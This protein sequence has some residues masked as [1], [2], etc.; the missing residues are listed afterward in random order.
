MKSVRQVSMV[1]RDVALT[2]RVT[3]RPKKLNPLCVRYISLVCAWG[4]EWEDLVQGDSPN[5]D[6]DEEA[7]DGDGPVV[8]N[9]PPA[10][11][12]VEGPVPPGVGAADGEVQDDHA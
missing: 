3:D 9:L 10:L 7:G 2:L 8:G 6:H 5:A 4:K 1:D 12:Y 11:D